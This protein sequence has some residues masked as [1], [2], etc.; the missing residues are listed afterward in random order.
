MV[1]SRNSFLNMLLVC[2]K[3]HPPDPSDLIIPNLH[4]ELRLGQA[5]KV[6]LDIVLKLVSAGVTF[7][8][9]VGHNLEY[10][11][12]LPSGPSQTRVTNHKLFLVTCSILIQGL[13]TDRTDP[14]GRPKTAP[15]RED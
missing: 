2:L 14:I 5:S 15:N 9:E 13:A 7:A 12:D 6:K 11:C 4:Y 1:A 10:R 8:A 3:H